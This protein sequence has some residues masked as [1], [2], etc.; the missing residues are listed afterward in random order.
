MRDS[1]IRWN[2]TDDSQNLG[3]LA[4]DKPSDSINKKCTLENIQ[5]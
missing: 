4:D 1:F 2:G 3:Q 5:N